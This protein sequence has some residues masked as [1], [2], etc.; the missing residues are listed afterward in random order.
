MNEYEYEYEGS[1]I[2][3]E[4]KT[5]N[6]D[7]FTSAISTMHEAFV[8]LEDYINNNVIVSESYDNTLIA[9]TYVC[10]EDLK[11]PDVVFEKLGKMVSKLNNAK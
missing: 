7:E 10:V 6:I 5:D 1:L 3:I 8:G 11:E 4:Y 2:N 9:G